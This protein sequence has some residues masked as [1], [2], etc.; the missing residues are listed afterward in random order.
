VKSKRWWLVRCVVVGVSLFGCSDDQE[1]AVACTLPETPRFDFTAVE[2]DVDKSNAQCPL[3]APSS[4]DTET[5]AEEAACEQAIVAC[6]IELNCDY[7]GLSIHG[8]MAESNGGLA[9]RFDIETPVTCLY[10]V[11]AKWKGPD[12]G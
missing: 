11:K 10:S 8:R 1:P 6:V 7:E 9:G 3:I 12:G 5:L 2:L 4:L